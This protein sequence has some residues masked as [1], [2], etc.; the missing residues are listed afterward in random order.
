MGRLRA[1]RFRHAL[2]ETVY[3]RK[4]ALVN[5]YPVYAADIGPLG[6]DFVEIAGTVT[7]MAVEGVRRLLTDPVQRCTAVEQNYRL[8][9][10]H[11]SYEVLQEKLVTLLG[12]LGLHG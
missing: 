11:F 4:P 7:D 1:R 8:G 5:R 6:F 2:I 9:Q 3:F 10:E 12:G